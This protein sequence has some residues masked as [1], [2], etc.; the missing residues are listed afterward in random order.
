MSLIWQSSGFAG[1]RVACFSDVS[2]ERVGEKKQTFPSRD[3]NPGLSTPF[4]SYYTDNA[5]RFWS[6]VYDCAIIWGIPENR[7]V[8]Y[9]PRSP[10]AG[11]KL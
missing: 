6:F 8:F 7:N 1:R 2:E 5:A 4:P 10:K 11:V 3:P 9:Y